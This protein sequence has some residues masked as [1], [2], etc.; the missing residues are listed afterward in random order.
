MVKTD[1][2]SAFKKTFRKIKHKPTKENIKTQIRKI[3]KEPE[4]G[5][6]MR[7]SRKE[8]R[9]LYVDSFRIS[10]AYLKEE[11]KIIFLDIY[12]KDKQ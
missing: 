4:T 7:Y 1:Y 6:P 8:T 3:I 2:H 9:E 12:H 10:Y 11:N 5:K